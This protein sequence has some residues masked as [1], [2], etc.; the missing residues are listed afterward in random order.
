V[1]ATAVRPGA[2]ARPVATGI[3]IALWTWIHAL[4]LTLGAAGTERMAYTFGLI[5]AVLTGQAELAREVALVSP[6]W[7]LVT[8]LFV[9]P[10]LLPLAANVLYLALFG[11]LIEGCIG[12]R[13]FAVLFGLSG[14]FAGLA[15]V[16]FAAH[17]MLP[18]AG[19]GGA[20]SG[21]IGA[22]VTLYPR[23]GM[24]RRPLFHLGRTPV[25]AAVLALLWLAGVGT[26]A[27]LPRSGAGVAWTAHLGGL[28]AGAV[29]MLLGPRRPPAAIA[30]RP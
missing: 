26:G 25:P 24:S 9:H 23:G 21:M 16:T 18:M 11:T 13:R 10:G 20:V 5:P 17:S 7:T 6:P 22:W 8:A 30:A 19:A 2:R 4:Q 28:L 3:L 27:V 15:Q 12:A 14:I 29:L 1:T